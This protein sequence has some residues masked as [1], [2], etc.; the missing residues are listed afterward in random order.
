MRALIES[1][2]PELKQIKA[3]LFEGDKRGGGDTRAV[4]SAVSWLLWMMGFTP[5]HFGSTKQLQDGPDILAT[6]P[7]RNIVMVECTTGMLKVDKLAKLAERRTNLRDRL[8]ASGHSFLRIIAAIA[9]TMRRAEIEADI[10]H[11]E[12][13][14]ILVITREDLENSLS[15]TLVSQDPEVGFRQ[16]EEAIKKAKEKRIS[17]SDH[18]SS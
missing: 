7:S 5:A 17:G 12:R 15:Q 8:N 13:L 9:T 1:Y 2:D 11:A 10:E 3:M 18:E 4:E 16:A 14:G 6:T